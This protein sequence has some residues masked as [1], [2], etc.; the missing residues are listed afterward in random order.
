[1]YI[2]ACIHDSNES[3]TA[4]PMFWGQATNI[5]YGEYCL[6]SEYV[7]NQ[8]WRPLTGSRWDTIHI[9][10]RIRDS[11]EIPTASPMFLGSGNTDGLLGILSYVWICHKSK[12]A[13]INR[14]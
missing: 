1:M 10:A 8:R 13:A 2:S 14:K 6:L 7:V 12:M 5:N 11:N 9:S 4:T 3:P